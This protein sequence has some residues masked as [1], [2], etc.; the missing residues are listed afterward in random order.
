MTTII[1]D[2]INGVIAADSQNTD[3]SDQIHRC[4]KIERLPNGN[5][6]LGSGHNLTISMAK[7]WAAAEFDPDEQPDWPEPIQSYAF[8]A[9]ILKPDGSA[10]MCDDELAVFE[11]L[12]KVIGIGSGSVYALGAMDAGATA[13]EA[14]MI[15]CRRD[16]YTSEPV[17][18]EK[19]IFPTKR[20]P[21]KR[22]D[23]L[24]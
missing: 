20:A 15:A 10:W 13:E 7:A 9:V 6:F 5:Y 22:R 8:S 16:L 17:H 2:R 11:L 21:R 3:C 23:T 14:L 19:I 18:L 12:D 24:R 4:N 1:V